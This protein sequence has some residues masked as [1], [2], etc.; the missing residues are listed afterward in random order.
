VKKYVL[1]LAATSLTLSPL[2]ALAANDGGG[3]VFGAGVGYDQ[4]N[5][6]DFIE[7]IGGPSASSPDAELGT[8]IYVGFAA[9]Q[10]VTVRFGHRRFGDA[11]SEIFGG[12]ADV[13]LEAD[14][15]Y[16]AVDL[17][18]PV[19]DRFFLGGT[20]GNQ[21]IDAE[22]SVGGNSIDDDARNFYYGARAKWLLGESSALTAAY[23]LYSF[24][25]DD[26]GEDIE[27]NTLAVGLEWRF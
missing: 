6:D 18:F 23:N 19:T 10:S 5:L 13:D 2:T 26:A 20:L 16:A 1:L 8:D 7:D 15:F 14:G 27:Y 21:G 22:L 12:L 3:V 24:E 17:L 25:V 11:E 4:S 9:N